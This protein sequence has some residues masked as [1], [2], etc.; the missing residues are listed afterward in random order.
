[1][2]VKQVPLSSLEEEFLIPGSKF[3]PGRESC[4]W[5]KHKFLLFVCSRYKTLQWGCFRWECLW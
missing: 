5:K 4:G 3:A 1:V 2:A